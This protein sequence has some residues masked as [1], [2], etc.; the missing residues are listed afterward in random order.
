M[1]EMAKIQPFT[2]EQ[3]FI[4]RIPQLRTGFSQSDSQLTDDST[5]PSQRCWSYTTTSYTL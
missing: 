4:D 3:Q 1:I 5:P 2:L